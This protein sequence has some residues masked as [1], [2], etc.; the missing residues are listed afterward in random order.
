MD[1]FQAEM[2]A[3][4]VPDVGYLP[5]HLAMDAMGI[6]H[7]PN[8][9]PSGS[10]GHH[11]PLNTPIAAC[12]DESD[13]FNTRRSVSFSSHSTQSQSPLLPSQVSM[14][15]VPHMGAFATSP[16]PHSLEQA[17]SV[18]AVSASKRDSDDE[19]LRA[20]RRRAQNRAAQR[21]YRQRK[22]Q[23]LKQRE[24]EIESLR[25][26]LDKARRLNKT[27]FR[28][29]FDNGTKGKGK[30][31]ALTAR[32][33]GIRAS[34]SLNPELRLHSSATRPERRPLLSQPD[35]PSPGRDNDSEHADSDGLYP[36]NSVQTTAGGGCPRRAD[37]FK[38]A[39]CS[40]YTNIHRIRRDI[41]TIVDDPYS[42]DQLKTPRL[43]ILVVRPLVDEYYATQDLSFVYCLLVNRMQFIRDQSL[44]SHHQTVNLTRALLCELLAEKILRRYNENLA[45]PRGLLKLANIL[46]AGFEPFQNAPEEAN[47][48][49]SFGK[50]TAL[51]VAIIT[52]SK[53]FLASNACQKVIDAIYKGKVVYSPNYNFAIIS[54]PWKHRPISLYDPWRAPVLNQYRLNVPRIRKVI[55]IFEFVVVLVLYMLVMEGRESG[56]DTEYTIVEAV[57]DV[58]TVGWILD[59]LATILEHGWHVYTQNLWSFLDVIFSAIFLTYLT[60]RL[61]GLVLADEQLAVTALDVLCCGATLLVPRLAFN[62]MAE[63]MLF[64]S[65]RAMMSDF[66]T[67]TILA[68]WCFVGFLLSLKWLDNGLY[69]PFTIS[70]WIIWIWFGLDGTGID[71]APEFHWFLGPALMV[72]FAF[73]GNTLFLTIL[74]SMLTNTFS[75]IVNNAVQEIQYRRAVQIFEG[76]HSDAI[77]AYTPP[78]NLIAL[79]V[80]LPL[81]VILTH[82]MFHKVNVACM[83]VVNFPTLLAIA[84]Y[85]RRTLWVSDQ[86]KRLWW[87]KIDWNNPFGP[88]ARSSS[89]TWWVR[90]FKAWKLSRFSAH[91]ALHIVFDVDPPSSVLQKIDSQESR[92]DSGVKANALSSVVL[93]DLNQLPFSL[94]R[95]TEPP[96]SAVVA[97]PHTHQQHRPQQEEKQEQE[98]KKQRQRDIQQNKALKQVFKDSESETEDHD[99][100]LDARQQ[101]RRARYSMR[102]DSITDM[103]DTNPAATQEANTRLYADSPLTQLPQVAIP[104]DDLRRRMAEFSL[105]FDTFIERARKRVLE[106]RNEYKA[107]ISE[108][109]AVRAAIAHKEAAQRE[110]ARKVEAQQRLNGP[111]LLFWQSYLAVRIEGAGEEEAAFELKVPDTT[112]GEY[113]VVYSRPRLDQDK[114]ARVVARLNET[115]EI[116]VLLKGMRALFAEG[117]D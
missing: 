108:I 72:S 9:T 71:K 12:F 61:H 107:R 35:V 88:R 112:T 77:F 84:W 44:H 117:M 82:H 80:L 42:L 91:G 49:S 58:Y 92:D 100:E 18:T 99:D 93:G 7:G 106:E 63:N 27:L 26:E 65:L 64:V 85:E 109:H 25:E 98:R 94:S 66:F 90:Q 3:H 68:V 104:F 5:P 19:T 34:G 1:N 15:D 43:N 6:V 73:L 116:G 48:N 47:G 20:E 23:S 10:S 69:S 83:R 110:Y 86:R 8:F 2:L 14:A 56:E 57:F 4:Q 103:N 22:D 115:R 76:V 111:E 95:N 16:F 113:Q 50:L 54:D 89:G 70:K 45:G 24:R 11:P 101:F 36:P 53:S 75:N 31:P 81:R 60:L 39:Q 46:V 40:V 41:R 55:E 97:S 78:F 32:L 33:S 30:P 13:P 114:V 59:Q 96:S 17:F 79:I 29:E 102:V 51:E 28:G 21:A 62:L 38:I 37:P 67:L 87:T 74:V 105:K 52:E